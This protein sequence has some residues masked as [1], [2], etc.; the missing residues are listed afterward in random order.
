MWWFIHHGGIVD[1]I[2]VDLN[3]RLFF[4]H[5]S[6]NLVEKLEDSVGRYKYDAED[7]DCID[8]VPSSSDFGDD[9][10]NLRLQFVIKM[11]LFINR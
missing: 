9:P 11:M 3:K 6:I 7:A 8:E 10:T 4:R 1:G 5:T 2:V